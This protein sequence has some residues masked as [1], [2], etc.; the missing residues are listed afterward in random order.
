MKFLVT[1]A[2][3][4]I[5]F[6][7]SQRLLAAGHQ[8]VGIDNLNDYYDVS[9]K[10]ARLDQILQ[11]PE[12]IFLKMDL[13]DRQAISSLFAEH[14]FDRVIHLGAQ[15]GVR[16]SIDNPHAYADAN[17]IGHLNILE[18]CRH[19]KVGHLLYASSSS[20]YGLNRKM[21]FS[22]D[23]SVDHPISLYAATKKANEL[24]SH[25]YSH[26]YQLPTTGLRFFTVYGPWGRPD[27]ALFKFTRA[28]LAGEQIDVYNR[29][30]MT[31]DF[32]YI[33]DIAEAIVRMQDV[34]PQA[35]ENWTVEAGSPAT[36][37]AP[38]RVYNIGNSQPTSLMTYIESLEKALG[39]EAKK[40]MLPMQPGDVLNTSADTQP[41]YDAIQFRP[42]TRVEQ[43]VQNFVDWYRRFYQQ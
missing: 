15:A 40:N 13:A 2:A 22:T 32:T 1:G 5:G 30:Q 20:V 31:R 42:Q 3:G 27:M 18:G 23:D 35:D 28:M 37:S 29:G 25:T 38:Y 24:M 12:F 17:L 21:P 10:Q 19:H 8:V 26:L 9:L 4:F 6:H 11:H 33:D 43:G 16:Y 39:I 41:L 7:V 34:I 14:A 36:S